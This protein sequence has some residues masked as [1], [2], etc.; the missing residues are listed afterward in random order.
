M[1]TPT[2]RRRPEVVN[3]VS[4]DDD[5]DEPQPAPRP[6]DAAVMDDYFDFDA[7]MPGAFHMADP[8]PPPLTRTTPPANDQLGGEYLIID[9]EQIFI[10]NRCVLC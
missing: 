4:D 2:A 8:A 9:G 5:S 7:G 1:A 3:L 10:P 6:R